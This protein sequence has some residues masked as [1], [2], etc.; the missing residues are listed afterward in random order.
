[1]SETEPQHQPEELSINDK[2]RWC[3]EN[4]GQKLTTVA[5]NSD[6]LDARTV[7]V[8][9]DGT[10]PMLASPKVSIL[11]D[12]AKRVSDVYGEATARAFLR[13]SNP[14]AD[15]QSLLMIIA[16]TDAELASEI[17]N[18]AVSVFLD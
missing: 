7:R 12:A 5:V 6:E 13:S 18:G 2:L 11:Y 4:L 15:D 1:M 17:V 14:E 16:Q 3:L 8:W 9:A 10:V